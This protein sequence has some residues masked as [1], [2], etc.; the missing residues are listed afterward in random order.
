MG[1]STAVVKGADERLGFFL[2]IDLMLYRASL[3]TLWWPDN[4]SAQSCEVSTHLSEAV[5][6]SWLDVALFF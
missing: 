5:F 4:E 2:L 6:V 1:K 3:Q